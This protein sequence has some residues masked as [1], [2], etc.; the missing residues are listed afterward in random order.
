MRPPIDERATVIVRET[1]PEF[2][3][4]YLDLLDL[5]G[6]DLTPEAVLNE[7]AEFAAELLADGDDEE[8]L[9]RVCAAVEAVA[10]ELGADGKDLVAFCFL[11][12]LPLFALEAIYSYLHPATETILE[13]LGRDLLSDDPGEP[14]QGASE[15]VF[16]PPPSPWA[17]G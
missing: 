5:Y 15:S 13:L 3:G 14:P 11:D 8:T 7:L 6:E 9:E 1:L 16:E 4:R 17:G 10:V 2:E 12:Q